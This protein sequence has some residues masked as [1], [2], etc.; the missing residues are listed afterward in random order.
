M[1]VLNLH[2]RD[3]CSNETLF[4]TDIPA[5]SPSIYILVTFQ[6]V[7]ITLRTSSDT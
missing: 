6:F 2:R 3:R 1:K 5:T 7:V 4:I